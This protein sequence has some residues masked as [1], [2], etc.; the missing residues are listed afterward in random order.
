MSLLEEI[1][2]PE[3]VQ[4]G[5]IEQWLSLS[6]KL[7]GYIISWQK[8]GLKS[9][10]LTKLWCDNQTV[11]HIASNLVLYERTK[12]VEV[13]C[14]FILEIIQEELIFTGYLKIKSQFGDIFTKTLTRNRVQYLCSELD[15]YSL[16]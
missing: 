4:N 7:C 3:R 13:H 1:W 11:I 16:T 9:L 12:H 6:V 8:T 15:I 5:N 2:C 14:H 10:L